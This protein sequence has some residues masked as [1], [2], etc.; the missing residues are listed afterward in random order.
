M[1]IIPNNIIIVPVNTAVATN[2]ITL[3]ADFCFF[4]PIIARI[5][6][7]KATAIIDSNNASEDVGLIHSNIRN[8]QT[9][10]ARNNAKVLNLLF[11]AS[12]YKL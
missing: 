2:E 11:I 10:P 7:T 3:S 1:S 8:P 5:L 9:S 6:P 4:T 12:S